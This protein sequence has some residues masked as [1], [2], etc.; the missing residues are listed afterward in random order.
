MLESELM[1]KIK[2]TL[3]VAAHV[4]IKDER[5]PPRSQGQALRVIDRRV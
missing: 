5:A 4:A 1:Q 3:G 2:S